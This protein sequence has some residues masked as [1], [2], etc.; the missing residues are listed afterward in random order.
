MPLGST[1]FIILST[2]TMSGC[3]IGPPGPCFHAEK[4]LHERAGQQLVVQAAPRMG[5]G[6]VS[7][8]VSGGGQRYFESAT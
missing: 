2:S 1:L 7:H 4:N 6:R 8:V 3:A 5:V